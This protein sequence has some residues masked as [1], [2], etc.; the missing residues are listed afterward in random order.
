[1][2]KELTELISIQW[3][4]RTVAWIDSAGNFTCKNKRLMVK[5]LKEQANV[6]FKI[7]ALLERL[8]DSA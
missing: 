4:G 1:M 3:D 8:R 6:W 2:S 7:D 5:A